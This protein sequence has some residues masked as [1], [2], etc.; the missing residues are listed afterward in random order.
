LI[1]VRRP[2]R[3]DPRCHAVLGESGSE[4]GDSRPGFAG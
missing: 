3:I 4:F 1:P 2:S